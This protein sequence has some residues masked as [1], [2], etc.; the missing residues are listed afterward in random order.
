MAVKYVYIAVMACV[1]VAI[2]ALLIQRFYMA[3][4]PSP[5]P[6]RLEE[7]AP[8][9]GIENVPEDFYPLKLAWIMEKS[10]ERTDMFYASSL[11]RVPQLIF[12]VNISANIGGS[13][14]EAVVEGDKLF[15]ADDQGIYAI[16]RE[17]GSLIW[18]VEVYSDSL[19]GRAI[20]Y[21]QPTNKW[22]ALGL[23]RFV[24]AYGLGKHLYVGTSSSP[25]G[26]NDAY[27]IAFNKDNG[28]LVWKVKLESES[29]A[30]SKASVTSNLI[31]AGGRVF[32]GSVRDE[33][34]V[35]CI[36]EE[37]VFQWRKK[38]GGNVR[39]L[40][41]GADVLYVSS[42]PSTKL[43]ALNPKT[44]ETI[45]IFEHDFMLSTPI[46]KSKR[47]ILS[48]SMG[49]LLAV[50]EDGKL[51][52]KKPLGISSDVNTNAFIAVDDRSIYAVRGI[53]ERP[54]NLFKL[55]LDGN[56]LG[57]FTIEKDENGGRPLVSNDVTILPVLQSYKY[58]KVYFLW[59]GI[60]KLCEFK[61]EGEEEIW[62]PKISAAYG[63]IYV[64]ANPSTLYKFADIKKPFIG[65]VRIQADDTIK[66]NASVCDE[67]SGLHGVYLVYSLNCS[68]WNYQP[69][70]ISIRYFTEPIGGYGFG[71]TPFPYY[72]M[73]EIPEGPA[74]LE[75]YILAIDNIGNYETSRVYAYR[76]LR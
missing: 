20:S 19:E 7:I 64:V 46:Y 72:T 12:K 34:Y 55:D 71:K 4:S 27:L 76:I 31:V 50:S 73:I 21:P 56:V 69:M 14:A 8:S 37:G 47:I 53:G 10:N 41:Y 2:A 24:E 70:D 57:N 32:V 35:F 61:F 9:K 5:T 38:V 11:P 33:G 23:W 30:T 36:T 22:R 39:G 52:W 48:D 3:P 51:L 15:L 62:M 60:F 29:N 13:L 6:I 16:S 17:D 58:N 75:F 43:Y 74:T 1:I 26:E 42:E 68:D 54:R 45:W 44:G 18:G 65:D 66:V 59:K 25:G 63:E 49:N 28:E 67:E 40:T